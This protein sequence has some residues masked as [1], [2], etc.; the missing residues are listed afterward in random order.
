MKKYLS[1]C[2]K[3]EVDYSGGGYDG[4]DIVPI[5]E[6]CKKC[7]ESLKVNGHNV[8]RPKSDFSPALWSG[9][10]KRIKGK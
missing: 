8:F 4:E 10:E 2:C 1:K 7:G 5:T 3:A 6:W 9:L